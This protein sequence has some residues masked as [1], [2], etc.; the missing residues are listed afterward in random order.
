MLDLPSQVMEVF[1]ALGQRRQLE[2]DS[3]DLEDLHLSQLEE[4]CSV[5]AKL[6]HLS[7][8][9]A[10]YLE[11]LHLV[12]VFLGVSQVLLNKL[13]VVVNQAH[14]PL[15][16]HLSDLEDRLKVG[17]SSEEVNK[18]LNKT[19]SLELPIHLSIALRVNS[20]LISLELDLAMQRLVALEVNSLCLVALANSLLE[21]LV[22]DFQWA[23]LRVV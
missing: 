14:L 9:G 18:L 21:D 6:L 10:V 4:A 7:Q 23:S 16:P 22:E 8:V 12:E 2:E 20:R 15:L 17:L 11:M 5:E 3:L 13:K 19:L 1:L